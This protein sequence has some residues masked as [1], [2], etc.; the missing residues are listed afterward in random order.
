MFPPS[1]LFILRSSSYQLP[2]PLPVPYYTPQLASAESSLRGEQARR[3]Q[4][5][6]QLTDEQQRS[7]RLQAEARDLQTQ[8][9]RPVA[10]AGPVVP[11]AGPMAARVEAMAEAPRPRP[12]TRDQVS[13]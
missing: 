4:L 10:M 7:W 1:P 3:R 12:E 8:L 11:M 9:M 13:V 5:A 2:L 6:D